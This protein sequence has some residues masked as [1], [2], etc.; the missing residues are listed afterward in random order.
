MN[1]LTKKWGFGVAVNIGYQKGLLSTWLECTWESC[2]FILYFFDVQIKVFYGPGNFMI[3]VRR[4]RKIR[5]TIPHLEWIL[6]P[7]KSHAK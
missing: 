6:M 2:S 1:G 4:P 3:R 7:S 5:V